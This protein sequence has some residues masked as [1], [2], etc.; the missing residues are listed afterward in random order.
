M[1]DLEIQKWTE[2]I[3]VKLS[4]D[5]CFKENYTKELAISIL[6]NCVAP[7]FLIEILNEYEKSIVAKL[8]PMPSIELPTTNK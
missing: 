3:A 4:C 1:K 6:S 7:V 2:T 8:K 5:G